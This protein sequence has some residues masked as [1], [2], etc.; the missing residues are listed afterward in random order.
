MAG[1][2]PL[3][4]K[5][6][7]GEE[8]RVSVVGEPE[9]FRRLLGPLPSGVSIRTGALGPSDVIVFFTTRRAD[10]ERRFAQLASR[11]EANGGL[12]VAW[13]KKSSS[14]R[15]DLSF[16]AVQGTGLAGGLVDNKSCSIDAEWQAL[17]FVYRLKDRPGRG[18][19]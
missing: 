9:G 2:T 1:D 19:G 18:A 14:I 13:P 12:W 16:E 11:L 8:A 4:K 15:N 17:R 3:R 7:I 10:F 5:L 6:G